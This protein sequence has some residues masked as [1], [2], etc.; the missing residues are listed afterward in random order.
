MLP[1]A[2]RPPVYAGDFP[3]PFVLPVGPRYF[4]YATQTGALNI[5]VMASAD[6]AAWEHLGDALPVLPSWAR[7]GRTWAP[8]A[9]RRDGIYVLYYTVRDRRSDRQCISLAVADAPQGP[10][11][12]ISAG[13]LIVQV[14]RGGSIDPSPFVD[15]GGTAYLLWKSDD[16]AIGRPSSIWGS[17]LSPDGLALSGEPVELLR[18][19]RKWERPLIEAPAMVRRGDRYYLFYSGNRWESTG[20]GIGYAISRTAS[21]PF[22]K[23]TRSRPWLGTGA[24]VAGPGGQEFFTD[25]GGG[26][27]MA[28]H[29]WAPGVVGYAAGGVRALHLARIGFDGDVPRL[30]G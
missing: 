29:G 17:A 13:P 20:Y 8:S 23:V 30:R 2:L 14:D 11:H 15:E 18:I 22:R 19:D 9:L 12:D 5:Q 28:F 24:A 3:D 26:I 27:W 21:G 10:F 25:R 6:L 7:P 1:E 4:A 16:N